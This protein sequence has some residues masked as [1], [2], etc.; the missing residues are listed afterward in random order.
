MNVDNLNISLILLILC[1]SNNICN[2]KTPLRKV[3]CINNILKK[4]ALETMAKWN[5][6]FRYIMLDKLLICNQKIDLAI[7]WHN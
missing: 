1:R 7:N 5:R 3:V 2:K 4:H 6:S